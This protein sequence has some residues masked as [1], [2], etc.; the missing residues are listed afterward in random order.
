M[1]ERVNGPL[2]GAVEYLLS[3]EAGNEKDNGPGP[4]QAWDFIYKSQQKLLDYEELLDTPLGD[5]IEE[6]SEAR[7]IQLRNAIDILAASRDAFKSK[8]VA[9]ARQILVE[10]LEG[11]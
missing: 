8:Q 10:L 2:I 4:D 5:V 9:R 1:T 11:T 7:D 3:Y 6:R